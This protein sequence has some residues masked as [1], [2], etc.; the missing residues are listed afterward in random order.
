MKRYLYLILVIVM[1][2]GVSCSG[3]KPEP[4]AEQKLAK[5]DEFF[6]RGKYAKAATIYD[7]ISF[8]RKSAA[9]AYATV[10]LADCYFQ[11]NKFVD[12]RL[13]YQQFID[14]FPDHT[15]VSD[16]YYRIAVCYFEE[17][18]SPHLDQY[19]TYLAIDAFGNFIDRYPRDPRFEQALEYIR[20]AQYKLIEK[21]YLN[22]Y[23]YY[24]MKDYSAALMYFEEVTDLG[25][26]DELDCKSLYYSA[27]LYRHQNNT[28]EAQKKYQVLASRYPNSK[29]H[30]KLKK[31]FEK[32]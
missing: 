28:E 11:Q 13:K 21:N 17:S 3:N 9:T 24:K 14:A 16:A 25:N 5:A 20:K 26:T 10:R 2:F 22:G 15:N 8:E 12:A 30:L 18:L 7:E 29:Q 32:K 31:K 27:L 4:T 23:I 1:I 6:A 19:E